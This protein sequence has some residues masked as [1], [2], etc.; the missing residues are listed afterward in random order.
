MIIVTQLSTK[1]L[2]FQKLRSVQKNDLYKLSGL[3]SVFKKLRFRDGLAWTVDLTVE[4]KLCFQISPGLCERGLNYTEPSILQM[5]VFSSGDIKSFFLENWRYLSSI[6]RVLQAN[7]SLRR[8]TIQ[9]F[10]VTE[11]AK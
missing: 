2:C 1:K 8:F 6:P 11:L 7:I 5:A 3:Q 9:S 4:I 10:K